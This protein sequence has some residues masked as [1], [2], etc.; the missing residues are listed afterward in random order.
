MNEDH[1]TTGHL[2]LREAADDHLRSACQSKMTGRHGRHRKRQA[3]VSMVD[4]RGAQV[5]R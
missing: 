2:S 3:A 5:G 4:I 1:L